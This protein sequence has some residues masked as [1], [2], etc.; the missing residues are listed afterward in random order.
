MELLC[1]FWQDCLKLRE[2]DLRHVLSTATAVNPTIAKMDRII[3]GHGVGS[4]R[5]LTSSAA[6]YTSRE[7]PA[8]AAGKL[9]ANQLPRA[10]WPRSRPRHLRADHPPHELSRN[11]SS[12]LLARLRMVFTT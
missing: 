1:D 12:G 5:K 10:R 4:V 9:Q 3:H 8:L 11:T 6:L 2:T 7:S